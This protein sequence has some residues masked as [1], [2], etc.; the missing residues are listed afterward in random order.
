MHLYSAERRVF[1]VF[2]GKDA[3]QLGR[4]SEL[5]AGLAL[6]TGREEG[7]ARA[8][9]LVPMAAALESGGLSRTDTDAITRLCGLCSVFHA[10]GAAR[11]GELIA[12]CQ[13]DAL[14]RTPDALLQEARAVLTPGLAETAFSFAIRLCLARGAAD[15]KVELRLLS[16]GGRLGLRASACEALLDVNQAIGPHL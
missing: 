13:D 3:G 16:L 8:V 7:L 15:E 4:I 14:M 2:C 11:T 12:A 1:G 6:A 5:R 9:I 10:I